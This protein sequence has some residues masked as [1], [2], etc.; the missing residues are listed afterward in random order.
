MIYLNNAAT[1]KIDDDIL[2]TYVDVSNKYYSS[3]STNY[4][5]LN[6]QN[7]CRE[8]ILKKLRYTNKKVVFTSN[9]TFANNLAI[10]GYARSFKQKKHFITSIYEHASVYETFKQI[11][12]EGHEVS[13]VL[14]NENGIVCKNDILNLVKNDTVM[15]SIM[16]VNNELGTHN[17]VDLIFEELKEIN[18]KIVVMSDCVQAIGKVKMPSDNCDIVTFSTH[19]IHGPKNIGVLI[20]NDKINL[21]KITYG[22]S[23]E[24]NLNPGTLDLALVVCLTKTINKSINAFEETKKHYHFIGQRIY[25]RIKDNSNLGLNCISNTNVF[26]IRLNSIM[27][28]QSI[29]DFL[30]NLNIE[31]STRSACSV[32]VKSDY[33]VLKSIGLSSSY[34]DKTI[35][36]SISKFTTIQEVDHFFDILEEKIEWSNDESYIN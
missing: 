33:R 18:S 31:V 26:S 13:Y 28:G 16:S 27:N 9:A 2:Q 7:Q 21:S 5:S 25:K 22:G 4:E 8:S 11:E 30:F 1:T 14:P 20:I 23:N 15:V 35:R 29:C 36:I 34:C 3:P 10:L 12:D 6:L 19:K 32:R 17:D 24:F